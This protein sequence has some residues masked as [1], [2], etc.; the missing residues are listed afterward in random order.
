MTKW[1]VY[2]LRC[3]DNSLYCG[4]TTDPQR[5]LKEHNSGKGAKYTSPR[6]PVIFETVMEVPDRSA[7]CRLENLTKQR[8]ASQKK[9]F[10]EQES[11]KLMATI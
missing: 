9:D 6:R 2:L 4:I 7:A 11:K 1:Y 10:L 3:S 5:R 8:P